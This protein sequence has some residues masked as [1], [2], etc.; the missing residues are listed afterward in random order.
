MV[1]I[2]RRSDITH[3]EFVKEYEKTGKPVILENATKV[4]KSNLMF[5]PDFFREK[6]GKVTTT[7]ANKE[8]SI[9]EVLELTKNST[10]ENPAP[11]PLKFNILSE[12]K[13]ML[14]LMEPLHLNLAT[15]NW[16]KSS[17]LK[18]KMGNAMDLHIG[19]AGNHYPV[20][21]DMYDVH[22]WLIQLYG[23]KD[24]Y[25]Y[26]KDQE[27]LM[28]AGT[29][30]ILESRSPIDISKP[31][32]EKYPKFKNATPTIVTLKAGEVMYIPS[33]VWHTTMAHGQNISTIIDQVNSSNYKGWRR[34]VYVYKAYFNKNRAIVDYLA[35]TAIGNLFKLKERL[36]MKP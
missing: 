2:D 18:N 23:E 11:Y 8:Y 19:G 31:D 12:L 3:K 24:V 4:W 5:T 36:G 34:T 33:G 7:N 21:K 27:D 13:E 6:F 29:G 32:Y 17:L 22:A 16:L 9:S 25:V 15:P 10:K 26:P 1:T 35:A 20:H 14:P 28:Y 30:G